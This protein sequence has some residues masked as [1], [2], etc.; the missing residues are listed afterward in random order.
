MEIGATLIKSSCKC[1]SH[2]HIYHST[3]CVA[4]DMNEQCKIC[5]E[6]D[7]NF[8]DLVS[9]WVNTSL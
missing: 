3:I 2:A 7:Q 1:A 9:H 8:T 4:L 6:S 5:G